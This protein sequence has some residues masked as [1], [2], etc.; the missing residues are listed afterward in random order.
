MRDMTYDILMSAVSHPLRLDGSSLRRLYEWSVKS[1]TELGKPPNTLDAKGGEFKGKR[2]LDFARGSKRLAATDFSKLLRVSCALFREKQNSMTIGWDF[3]A[4]SLEKQVVISSSDIRW[5]P[6]GW[7]ETSLSLSPDLL[8]LSERVCLELASQFLRH[9]VEQYGFV[10]FMHRNRGPESYI[11]GMDYEAV[12]YPHDRT[13]DEGTNI[14]GWSTDPSRRLSRPW[15]RDVY[16]INFLGPRLGAMPMEGTTL[17]DWLR[18]DPSRGTVEP[19]PCER[20]PKVLVWK[21]PPREIPTLR[22]QLYRAGLIWHREYNYGP[23]TPQEPPP[24]I[25]RAEFYRGRDPRLTR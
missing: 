15:L 1:L 18:R 4:R 13:Y 2:F 8:E 20:E 7:W 19:F 22:E 11:I 16:P 21:P 12:R 23:F 25:M 3:Q 6:T 10:F 9:T 5:E 17:V 24:E 14:T